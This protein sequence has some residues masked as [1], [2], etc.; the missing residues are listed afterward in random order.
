MGQQET[1]NKFIPTG[2]MWEDLMEKVAFVQDFENGRPLTDG[3]I[4]MCPEVEEH[5][6]SLR[7]HS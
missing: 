1:E 7:N 6:V 4:S 3:K 5:M 2:S